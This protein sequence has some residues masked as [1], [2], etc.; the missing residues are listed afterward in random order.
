MCSSTPAPPAADPKISEY[1]EKQGK[2]GEE[3]WNYMKN[4]F[5]PQSMAEQQ[6]AGE[7]NKR[8]TDEQIAMS[9]QQR[10]MAQMY[11]DR[12]TGKL[13]PLQDQMA[14]EA[15]TAGGVGE[16][17]L[18]AGEAKADVRQGFAQQ[19]GMEARRMAALGVNPASGAYQGN[20]S[21]GAIAEALGTASA[22]TRARD[23]AKQLGWAKRSDVAAGLQGM[24]G[25]QATAAGTAMSGFGQANAMG[26][27]PLTALN[28]GAGTFSG[29]MSAA[30]G[31][32]GSAG[33]GFQGLSNYA[34]QGW[35]GQNQANAQ[36]SAGTGQLVGML[37][38]AAIFA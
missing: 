29:G 20:E 3:Q 9:Q 38:S 6:R 14:A 7:I 25:G 33:S 17:Q 10:G 12:L 35:Q 21:R 23:M 37:G 5:L 31:S 26:Y 24:I 36:S 30:G 4:T 2:I 34:M 11:Q 19:R 16:Q 15:M 18:R 27:S 22:G 32:M 13:F 28:Q 1:Y 8:M